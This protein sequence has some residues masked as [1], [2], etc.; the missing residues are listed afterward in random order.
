MIV[1]NNNI[2]TEEAIL[3]AENSAF[4]RRSELHPEPRW[5][6]HSA[7]PDPL[8]GGEGVAVPA[9]EPHPALGSGVVRI[10]LLLFLAGCRKRRLNRLSVCLAS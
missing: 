5:G 8:A 4:F 7:L 3:S 1:H 2:N 6:A 10:D 9:Q